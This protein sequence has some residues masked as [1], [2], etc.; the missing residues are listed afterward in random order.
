MLFHLADVQ[1]RLNNAIKVRPVRPRGNAIL[2][3]GIPDLLLQPNVA[4]PLLMAPKV[5][6][7]LTLAPEQKQK[8]EAI[9]H[10]FNGGQTAVDFENQK[11][12]RDRIQAVLLPKQIERANQ[13]WLQLEPSAP[14]ALLNHPKV[15]AALGFTDEQK[16]ALIHLL[17]EES[18]RATG[19]FSKTPPQ[20]LPKLKK[21]LLDEMRAK[22]LDLLTPIQKEKYEN[23][24]GDKFEADASQVFNDRK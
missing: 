23:M 22:K 12:A 21:S 7:E 1:K 14:A 13:I 24:K 17:E 6:A 15:Q 10:E 11:R 9:N 20:D 19:L 2:C 16:T 3:Q 4:L 18:R 8:L 5:Q